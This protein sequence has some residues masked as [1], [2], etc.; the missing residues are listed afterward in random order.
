MV[1]D[2]RISV[3]FRDHRKRKKLA[4]MIGAEGVL[5]LVDLWIATA[6]TH[7]DGRLSG[8]DVDD[9]EI[10]AGWEGD[11]GA[12][13]AACL[14]VGWIESDGE[15]YVLHD[16]TEHQSYVVS[17]SARSQKARQAA[18]AR[19]STAQTAPQACAE[20]APSMPQACAEHAGSN[21]PT[22]PY[23]TK[24]NH[25]QPTPA[26]S[27]PRGDSPQKQDVATWWNAIAAAT[28]IPAVREIT[29]GRWRKFQARCKSIALWE[30]RDDIASQIHAS[31]PF[32]TTGGWF[33]LDW[34]LKNDENPSKLLEGNYV[35]SL[36][37]R[38]DMSAD[39]VSLDSGN[40]RGAML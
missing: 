4:R 11:P 38:N 17:S 37:T 8:M 35:R 14:D 19:W 5:A 15:C 39:W 21:A 12:F 30:R 16:W 22:L 25:T 9:I 32:L 18:M 29:S 7:P 33:S 13:L 34:L 20:H 36:T 40:V 2:I 27:P 1:S 23:P 6:E 3:S 24:P 28:G 31:A 26:K 10:D